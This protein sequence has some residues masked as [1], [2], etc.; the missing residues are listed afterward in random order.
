MSGRRVRGGVITQAL[1]NALWFM[2]SVTISRQSNDWPYVSSA[3]LLID[4]YTANSGYDGKRNAYI[5][6]LFDLL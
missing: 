6:L 3:Q 4:K 2:E 1:Q 5:D